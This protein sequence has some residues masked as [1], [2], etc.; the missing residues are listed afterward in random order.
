MR[1]QWQK[2]LEDNS[3]YWSYG[4]VPSLVES[5]DKAIKVGDEETAKEILDALATQ[6]VTISKAGNLYHV[7]DIFR[8][9]R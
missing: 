5:L 1:K 6:G 2:F 8:V 7:M 4:I 3:A 9:D